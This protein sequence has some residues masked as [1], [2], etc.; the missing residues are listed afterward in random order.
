MRVLGVD[1]GAHGAFALYDTDL[2]ALTVADMP[3]MPVRVGRLVRYQI[4]E[5]GIALI[6]QEWTPDFAWIERV[7]A[8]PK[9]GTSSS[10]SFG[11]AYGLARGVLAA[12]AVP[13]VLVTPHEWK[14]YFRLGADK[15][16][17]RLV[18]SRI[19]PANAAAFSRVR[20]DGRA[21]AALLA[22]FGA[23]QGV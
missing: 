9:Q 23:L 18:A 21:E 19:F 14:K 3:T 16:E 20:D 1:P 6:M 11:V 7:H 5:A 12:F 17:A 10:F 8:R 15:H 4:S 22:R 13:V 2:D